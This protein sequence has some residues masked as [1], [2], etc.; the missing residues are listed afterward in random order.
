MAAIF[1]QFQANFRFSGA[2][3]L[4]AVFCVQCSACSVLCAV[5]CVQCS[6]CSV[7]CAVFCVQCHRRSGKVLSG[8]L[9]GTM[10]PPQFSAVPST[11]QL[12]V[13][14]STSGPLSEICS[15]FFLLN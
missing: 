4:C 15:D 8:D 11:L 9:S 14:S 13:H 3:V 12:T 1:G 7:L 5:F 10:E 2:L 6:V